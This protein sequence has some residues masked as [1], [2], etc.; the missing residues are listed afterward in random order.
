MSDSQALSGKAAAAAAP[1]PAAFRNRLEPAGLIRHFLENPP[2]GF[3]PFVAHGMPGFDAPFDL[4]TT[5]DV[6]VRRGIARLPGSRLWQ[7]LLRFHT[8]FMGTTVSEYAPFPDDASAEALPNSLLTAWARRTQFLIVKD[9]PQASP[10]LGDADATWAADFLETC[11]SRDFIVVDGQALAYVAVDT[12]S[13]DEYLARLST[14]RRKNI[15]R[16]LRVR[17][18]LRVEI[19]ETGH[20]R[21]ADGGFLDLLYSLYLAVYA[22]SD[23]H[24]DLLST[25]FFKAVFQDASLQGRLFLYYAGSQLIGY[26]LCFVHEQMLIDKYV[27][28]RYPDARDFNLYFVSWMEN[29]AY[30]RANGLTHYVAGWTDPEVKASLG[31]SFTFTRHAVFVRNPVLRRVL[32]RLSRHFESDHAWFEKS[33]EPGGAR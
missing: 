31:A 29:L 33:V 25:G 26:N 19:L 1:P 3:T 18:Q 21:F 20:D 24:F 16:K 2:A 4:L 12:G 27:G 23:I 11:R 5:V 17:D 22:Q 15:R 7:K 6:G 30:A 32:R 13:E 9:I 14:G 10:L 8:C 28:F